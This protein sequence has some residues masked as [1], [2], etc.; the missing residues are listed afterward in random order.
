MMEEEIKI[1]E[2]ERERLRVEAQRLREELADLKIETEILQDKIRKQESRH[3]STISTDISIPGSPSF[4]GSPHST[5]SSPVI[6]TPPDT[7]SLST[8]ETTSELQDPPSPPMSD[9]SA[10]FSK[11]PG[12]RTPALHRKGRFAPSAENTI[13]PKPRNFTGSTSTSRSSRNANTSSTTRSPGHRTS[14]SRTS[15]APSHKVPPPNSLSHIRSLTA[16]MQRLEARVQSARSKLPS[17]GPATDT[18]SR[19]SARSGM[20]SVPS[21]VTIRTRKRTG[22]STTSSVAS[23]AGDEST[24]LQ[25]RHVP[26]L[27]S[28]GAS[29]LSF[30]PLPNRNPTYVEPDISRPSSRA[31]HSSYATTPSRYDQSHHTVTGVI[32]PPRPISRTTLS[33]SRTSSVGRPRSSLGMKGHGGHSYSHSHGHSHSMNYHAADADEFTDNVYPPP[34]RRG[35][36]SRMEMEAA[37]GMSAIPVPSSRRQSSGAASVSGRRTSGASRVLADLGETY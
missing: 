21:T 17:T 19:P 11:L 10:P 33:S 3:L 22:G 28:S 34:S 20:M 16:Q 37:T 29:R 6:T 27:S 32:P 5:A 31:S 23:F 26:R 15:R 14:S 25:S 36:F 7:K 8:A 18:P 30:G 24:P 2:Q 35:T 13:T 1:G 4:V 12:T 9:A